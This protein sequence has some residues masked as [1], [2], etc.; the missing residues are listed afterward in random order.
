MRLHRF[1]RPFR[2]TAFDGRQDSLVMKLAA[3]RS[4][5]HIKNSHP[6]LAKQAHNGIEQRQDERIRRRFSQ[7]QMEVEVSVDEGIRVLPPPVYDRDC[8]SHGRKTPLLH[9]RWCQPRGPGLKWPRYFSQLHSSTE[10][11]D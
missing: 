2:V 10:L 11:P 9:T 5:L 3:L 7:R 4:A 8:V 1:A 6:L